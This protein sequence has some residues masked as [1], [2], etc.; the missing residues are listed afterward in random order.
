T[1]VISVSIQLSNKSML[2]INAL[3]DSGAL[4]C[5]LNYTLVYKYNLPIN[6]K[7]TPLSVEVIDRREILSGAVRL[8]YAAILSEP[9]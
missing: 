1:F 2:P 8:G 4:A 6:T 5:F 9:L 7:S 3:I